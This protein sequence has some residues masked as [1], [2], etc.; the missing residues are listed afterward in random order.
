MVETDRLQVIPLQPSALEIYLQGEGKLEKEFGLRETGRTVSADVRDRVN[1]IILPRLKKMNGED[2]LFQTFWII[3]EKSSSIIVAELGFKGTPDKRGN[4]EIG[5]GTLPSYRGQGIMTEAVAGMIKW[6]K[7]HPD[8]QSILAET[9]LS[10]AASIRVMEK[11][12]FTPYDLL[13]NR[14][15]WR[16]DV[17][18]L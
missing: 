18:E 10:N 9:D 6:A 3:I 4:I 11:N 5:Y 13:E 14:R 17:S 7:Q 15:W 8:V 2:Y 16:K 1:R 12:Q